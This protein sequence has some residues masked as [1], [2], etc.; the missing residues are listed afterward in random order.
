LASSLPLSGQRKCVI[1]PA[2]HLPC[3]KW[4]Y[5]EFT[6]QPFWTERE[7]QKFGGRMWNKQGVTAYAICRTIH[8]RAQRLLEIPESPQ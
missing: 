5:R 1:P 8:H 4:S 3:D 6:K 7:A 2:L